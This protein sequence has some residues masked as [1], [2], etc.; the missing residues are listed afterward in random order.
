LN[1]KT[2][3]E[4]RSEISH[5]VAKLE[6]KKQH[7]KAKEEKRASKHAA[8]LLNEYEQKTTLKPTSRALS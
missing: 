1:G 2:E 3:E 7:K 6:K 8:E 4:V 5:Y